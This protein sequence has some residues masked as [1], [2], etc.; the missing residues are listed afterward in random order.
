MLPHISD[1]GSL[2][3]VPCYGTGHSWQEGV[4]PSQEEVK[5]WAC[6]RSCSLK[7][8]LT[9]WPVV[10]FVWGKK[11]LTGGHWRISGLTWMLISFVVFFLLSS[12]QEENQP[13]WIQLNFIWDLA[14]NA[15][16]FCLTGWVSD[17]GGDAIR[18]CF[19]WRCFI[20]RWGACFTPA[21]D[22]TTWSFLSVWCCWY[23]ALE[24][25]ADDSWKCAVTSELVRRGY[26]EGET[27]DWKRLRGSERQRKT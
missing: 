13:F 6:D 24:E 1:P 19:A 14:A 25:C 11:C 21:A 12:L 10:D 7:H 23:A 26:S 5:A 20:A 15:S 4:R 16:C 22:I 17:L 18:S 2:H 3:S 9:N 27:R 8:R